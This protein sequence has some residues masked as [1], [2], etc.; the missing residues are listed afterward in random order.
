MI[1]QINNASK[2]AFYYYALKIF[3]RQHLNLYLSLYLLKEF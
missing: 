3:K 1:A 2:T